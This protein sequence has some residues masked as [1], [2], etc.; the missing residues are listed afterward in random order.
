MPKDIDK[1]FKRKLN[2]LWLGPLQECNDKEVYDMVKAYINNL[3]ENNE[4]MQLPVIEYHL[5][6]SRLSPKNYHKVLKYARNEEELDNVDVDRNKTLGEKVKDFFHRNMVVRAIGDGAK[7]TGRTIS[8]TSKKAVKNVKNH[9]I[10]LHENF[11][12]TKVAKQMNRA[13]TF[14]KETRVGKQ[15]SKVSNNFVKG[16]KQGVPTQE[17][18]AIR[19]GERKRSKMDHSL[20]NIVS[21]KDFQL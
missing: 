20:D 8:K 5:K 13:S 10:T 1:N 6:K 2:P 18:Q 3:D 16:L 12:G 14:I 19:A 9:A 21:T 7:I 4:K 11:Q 15:I 17:E